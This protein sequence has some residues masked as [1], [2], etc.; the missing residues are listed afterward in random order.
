MR[1]K[2]SSEPDQ[3]MLRILVVDD[4]PDMRTSLRRILKLKGYE[5]RTAGS[6][7]EAILASREFK[8]D[9]IL[10]DI[11]MPGMDGVEAFRRIRVERPESFVCFMTAHSELIASA[12][13][14]GG[15]RVL[16][17][18]VDLEELCDLVQRESLIRPVLIVDDDPAFSRSLARLLAGAGF[19]VD[20]AHNAEM[21]SVAFANRPRAIVLLDVGLGDTSGLELIPSLRALNPNV[22]VIAISG[23]LEPPQGQ[24]DEEFAFLPKPLDIDHLL[25]ALTAPPPNGDGN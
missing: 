25:A 12:K 18:P 14:E 19:R 4:E 24:T 21:A 3:P 15:G 13:Q 8:P 5:V 17:K 23:L 22:T 6:G 16:T 10:M 2:Q 11:R 20:T 7:E 9:G 1:D